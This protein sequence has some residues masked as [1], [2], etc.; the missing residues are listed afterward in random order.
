[1]I[2]KCGNKRCRKIND[3]KK[4]NHVESIALEVKTKSEIERMGVM[5][6][7]EKASTKRL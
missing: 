3:R 6:V 7:C 4:G 5:Q 1:M 2:R